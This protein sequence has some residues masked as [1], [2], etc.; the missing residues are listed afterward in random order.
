ME[1]SFSYHSRLRTTNFSENH[2]MAIFFYSQ[3]CYQ[4]SAEGK[5]SKKYFFFGVIW[6]LNRNLT[7]NKPT[8]LPRFS[9]NFCISLKKNYLCLFSKLLMNDLK[10]FNFFIFRIKMFCYLQF[11]Y[12]L[13]PLSTHV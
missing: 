1:T 9:E 2:F 12:C 5:S 3:S 6:G 8:R 7:S 13:Y 4:S 11:S 10:S